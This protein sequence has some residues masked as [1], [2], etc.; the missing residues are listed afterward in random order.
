MNIL[1]LFR[2]WLYFLA[3]LGLVIIVTISYIYDVPISIFTRDQSVVLKGTPFHGF[4]SN[5][6]I[7]FW[8][9]TAAISLFYYVL[10]RKSG[11][12]SELTKFVLMGG[13]LTF[14]LLL[15][16]F[17]MFHDWIFPR[18][19][20]NEKIVLLFYAV[21]ALV[22]LVKFKQ[23]I[24]RRDYSL[25]LAALFFFTLSIIEDTLRFL[26]D[27]WHYLFED[28]TKFLGIVSWFGY[29]VSLYYQEISSVICQRDIN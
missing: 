2:F 29:Y 3:V 6:G 1:K 4:L 26:P 12:Q 25:L 24:L 23:F 10:L 17:F 5:I 7:L 22:Y 9:W 18:L 16:D 11:D 21:F 8:S 19:G 27:M 13:L 20:V 15:D 14:L 28:G